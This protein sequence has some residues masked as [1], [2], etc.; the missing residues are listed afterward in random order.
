MPLRHHLIHS[1]PK[2]HYVCT[3]GRLSFCAIFTTGKRDVHDTR[4]GDVQIVSE[5]TIFALRKNRPMASGHIPCY[6]RQNG[7]S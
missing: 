4:S 5:E 3:F 7:I 2:A 1:L 6:P